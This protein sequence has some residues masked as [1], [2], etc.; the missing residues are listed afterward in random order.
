[1]TKHTKKLNTQKNIIY[2]N[3]LLLCRNK[4]FYTKFNLNDTFQNR[5]HLIFIHISFLFIKIKNDSKKNIYKDFY[6]KLFDFT[7]N[8][9]HTNNIMY[10]NTDAKFLFYYQLQPFSLYYQKEDYKS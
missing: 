4:V 7:H 5:I 2:N 1:M 10:K 8:D 6:Q 3:I 9:L